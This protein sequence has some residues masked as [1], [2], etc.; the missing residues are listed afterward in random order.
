MTSDNSEPGVAFTTPP[1]FSGFGMIT[2]VA[3]ISFCQKKF[4][5]ALAFLRI[6]IQSLVQTQGSAYVE[7]MSE[8]RNAGTR[9]DAAAGNRVFC[10]VESI[11]LIALSCSI[12][13]VCESSSFAHTQKSRPPS[14][15]S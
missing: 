11:I 5:V 12:S 3:N 15:K 14:S 8:K 9:V 4:P 6:S 2:L 10:V 1:S 13:P 7:Q